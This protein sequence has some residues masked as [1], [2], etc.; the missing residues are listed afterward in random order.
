MLLHY[1]TLLLLDICALALLGGLM[2]HAW[3]RSEHETTLGFLA[4]MLLLAALGT[5]TH[6]LRGLGAEALPIVLANMLL[7]L[8]AGLGWTAMRVFATRPPWWPGVAGGALL[9]GLLCLWPQFMTSLPL[10]VTVGTLLA[11]LY[12]GLSVWEL[13]RARHRLEVAI[14]PAVTL[15]LLHALFLAA[16][17]LVGGG[18]SIVWRLSGE[19]AGFIAWRLLETLLFATGIAFITLAMVHERAE[20]RYRAVANRDPL[21]EIGNRRAFME[22][23]QVLLSGCQRAGRPAALLLCD[24]DHFK[25][26][27][28]SH[29]HALGDAAL[30]AFGQVLARSV[31][32]QDVCGRIGGE[33]FAC[34]LA[35]ADAS[36]AAQVAERIRR[37]CSEL[38]LQSTEPVSMSVSIGLAA[39]EQSGYD[40]AIL[41]GRADQALYRAKAGGR[42]RVELYRD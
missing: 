5:A 16:L 34:L 35:D 29:G 39:T 1:P 33:E 23:A 37:E 18:E 42:D 17:L 8:A 30:V 25:R 38:T 31:R 9:W 2:L 27:N 22:G 40:L 36:V 3:W 24:L 7:L 4:G 26:L 15:L 11:I 19:G 21:T 12:T 32:Q 6:G 28:D 41:L 14:A 10:R 20:V 13:W